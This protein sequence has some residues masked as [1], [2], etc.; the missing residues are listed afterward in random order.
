MTARWTWPIEAAANASRSK[1]ANAS[2]SGIPSSSRSSFSIRLNGSGGTSS[3]SA[4]S[5]CL[6]SSR[7]PSGIAVKSTVESTWPIFI[8]APRICPSCST[9]SR[10]SA[11]ARSP[12]RRVGALGRAD[13]VGGARPGPAQ[14]LAGDEAADAAGAGDAGAGG[15]LGSFGHVRELRS[16]GIADHTHGVEVHFFETPAE[17]RA[18]LEAQPRDGGRG[19]GRL[20]AQGERAA[21][22][23]VVAGG[24]RGAVLRLD[25]RRPAL[26]RRDELPEPLHAAQAAQH[27]EQGQ[28]RQGRGAGGRGEDDAGRAAP[29]SS[30][31]PRT[32]RGST[33]SRATAPSSLPEPTRPCSP[34]TRRRARTSRRGRASYRRA[35]VHWVT[36]AKRRGDARAPPRPARGVLRRRAATCRRSARRVTPVPIGQETPVPPSPQ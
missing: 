2:P 25:R 23:D 5:V 34:P 18:W 1:S 9:S 3:R 32:T 24:R 11:A 4:A 6:N 26:D 22:D 12:G 27:L 21:L 33:P 14:A 31:A 10:A 8:A 13:E 20:P 7:S 17:W 30:A 36:S 35:A 28:H 19:R 15:S 16:G 29:R